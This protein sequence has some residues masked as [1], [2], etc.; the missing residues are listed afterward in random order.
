M[1]STQT[2]TKKDIYSQAQEIILLGF[3]W[4][5]LTKEQKTLFANP[6]LLASLGVSSN[7]EAFNYLTTNPNALFTSSKEL[8]AT[9]D[10]ALTENLLEVHQDYL[11]QELNTSPSNYSI[12]EQE[13]IKKLV[14]IRVEEIRLEK[15]LE[16]QELQN[17]IKPEV[18]KLDTKQNPRQDLVR[19][20]NQAI[21]SAGKKL[22]PLKK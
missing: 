21:Q 11:N 19:T 1:D 8:N 17:K 22:T 5:E 2:I 13:L 6:L 9:V 14:A 12:N 7:L 16:N 3:T 20:A 4:D 18:D 10:A 15:L